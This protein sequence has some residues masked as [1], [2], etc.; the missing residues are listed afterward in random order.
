MLPG[1]RRELHP[2]L[3]HLLQFWLACSGCEL[4]NHCTFEC[5]PPT[6][7]SYSQMNFQ[8]LRVLL[9]AR[10]RWDRGCGCHIAYIRPVATL[11]KASIHLIHATNLI[12]LCIIDR[13]LVFIEF[14]RS[15]DIRR[16]YLEIHSSTRSGSLTEFYQQRYST[17]YASRKLPPQ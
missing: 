2:F 11:G 1:R 3:P 7:V 13:V 4:V 5:T 14:K 16:F 6:L 17:N 8:L 12:R 10:D 15:K 9:S